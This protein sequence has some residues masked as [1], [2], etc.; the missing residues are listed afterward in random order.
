MTYEKLRNPKG[1]INKKPIRPRRRRNIVRNRDS[2]AIPTVVPVRDIMTSPVISSSVDDSVRDVA[3]KMGE[4]KIGSIVI[5][6]NDCPA[7]I[8]YDRDIVTIGVASVNNI[9]ELKAK[10]IMQELRTIEADANIVDA[11]RLFRVH[12]VKRLGVMDKEK[13]VG[14]ISISDVIAVEPNLVDVL[15]EKAAIIRYDLGLP[16]HETKISGYC[17]VCEEWSDLL[18]YREGAFICEGCREDAS[19]GNP[20]EGE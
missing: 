13:L 10:E 4:N 18:Q 12:N 2:S 6:E 8:I 3:K 11:A 19:V 9:G 15:S 5:F 7:G 20:A 17:D 16:R 1:K 14:I